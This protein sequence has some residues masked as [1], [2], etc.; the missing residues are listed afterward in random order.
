ME[1]TAGEQLFHQDGVGY[2]TNITGID[3]AS[4]DTDEPDVNQFVLLTKLI[5]KLA[6]TSQ[7]LNISD[8]RK[9]TDRILE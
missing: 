4:S 3:T 8:V 6:H 7:W 1:H 9:T 2:P 5:L